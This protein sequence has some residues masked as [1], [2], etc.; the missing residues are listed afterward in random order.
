MEW[1]DKLPTA[2]KMAVLTGGGAGLFWCTYI[3]GHIR[4]IFT[5]VAIVSIALYTLKSSSE[6]KR[7]AKLQAKAEQTQPHTLPQAPVW[8]PYAAPQALPQGQPTQ[9]PYTQ[10]QHFTRHQ[11]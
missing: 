8:Q 9:N 4:T 1:F 2:L 10:H 11:L 3:V 6:R 7:A 5:I